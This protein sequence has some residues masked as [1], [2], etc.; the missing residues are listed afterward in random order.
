MYIYGTKP[1]GRER[2]EEATI[3]QTRFSLRHF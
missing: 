1:E 3:I 2:K